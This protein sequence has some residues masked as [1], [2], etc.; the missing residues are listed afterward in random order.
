MYIVF[1]R[2]YGMEPIGSTTRVNGRLRPRLIAFPMKSG[3]PEK[4]RT[5]LTSKIKYA[6]TNI[7]RLF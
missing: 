3:T 6:Y 7:Q 1:V 2:T 4:S 5:L